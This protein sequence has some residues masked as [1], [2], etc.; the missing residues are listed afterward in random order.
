MI[1]L[2]AMSSSSNA[3]IPLPAAG[4]TRS[5]FYRLL[6]AAILASLALAMAGCRS[7]DNP[8]VFDSDRG[9]AAAGM[10]AESAGTPITGSANYSTNELQD[11]DLI[12]INFQ[13]STNFDVVQKIA[14][15]GTLNL[16][17]VGPM[18]AAGKTVSQLQQDVAAAYKTLAKDDVVTVNLL[19]STACVYVDGAVLRPGT[20][21]MDRP[22]TVLEAIMDAGG[23]DNTRAKLSAVTVL[24]VEQGQQ[25]TY[26]INLHRVLDGKDPTPFYVKPFDVIY[27]PA[28]VFNY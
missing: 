7:T 24:R 25:M 17:M 16:N 27:V 8:I 10:A 21:Q 14:L 11:G 9:A 1:D 23:F 4:K 22:L 26:R 6:A 12:S 19:T 20:V 13:Y 15:D 3:T 18:K 5:F 28:K 2:I